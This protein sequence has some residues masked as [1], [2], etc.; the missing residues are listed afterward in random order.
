MNYNGADTLI[1]FG[2][3]CKSLPQRGPGWFSGLGVV[4]ST[5]HDADLVGEF[6]TK[7]TFYGLQPGDTTNTFYRHGQNR[8]LRRRLLTRS[9][10]SEEAEGIRFTGQ[11]NLDDPYQQRIDRLIGK[12]KMGLS[13]GSMGHLVGREPRGNAFEL[14][15]FPIG[16]L[17]ITPTPCEPKTRQRLI[18]LKSLVDGYMPSEAELDAWEQEE[19]ALADD[20]IRRVAPRSYNHAAEQKAAQI[21]AD[22]LMSQHE[23]RMAELKTSLHSDDKAEMNDYYN[24]MANLQMYKLERMMRNL[25]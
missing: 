12:G 5:Q 17:S 7:Q 1:A 20:Y 6:F 24:A 10:F 16:E 15:S 8:T 3:A 14:T 18:P 23:M 19:E 22:L 4:Y 25:K 21:Y 13:T 9:Y 2:G 11:L